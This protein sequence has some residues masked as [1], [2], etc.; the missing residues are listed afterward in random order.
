VQV[1]LY[2]WLMFMSTFWGM[3]PNVVPQI[4]LV[5]ETESDRTKLSWSERVNQ[6]KKN[7]KN[8]PPR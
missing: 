8:R 4:A 3:V 7:Q 2:Y 1:N 5:L 6:K